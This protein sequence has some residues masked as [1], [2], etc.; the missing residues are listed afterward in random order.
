MIGVKKGEAGSTVQFYHA[1]IKQDPIRSI[2]VEPSL[3]P[4]DSP[5]ALKAF[6]LVQE[7]GSGI[8]GETFRLHLSSRGRSSIFPVKNTD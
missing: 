4:N 5:N 7:R 8:S 2:S 6:P 3:L 1:R